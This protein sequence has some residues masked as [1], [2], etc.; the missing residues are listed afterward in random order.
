MKR[1]LLGSLIVSASLISSG[2]AFAYQVK[3]AGVSSCGSYLQN[4]VQSPKLEHL[5]DMHWV[6]GFITGVNYSRDS[7]YGD[8]VD[9]AG[10][11]AFLD[12]Y[13]KKNPLSNLA[14]ASIAL[15]RELH[16]R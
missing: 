9:L 15:V 6:Y 10:I 14:D 13:C 7:S 5:G 3:G 8:G 12:S 4:S 11:E 16:N 2:T 1:L